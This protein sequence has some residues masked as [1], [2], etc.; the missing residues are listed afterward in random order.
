MLRILEVDPIDAGITQEYVPS[1]EA[2]GAWS[3]VTSVSACTEL[4]YHSEIHRHSEADLH[5][6]IE[7]HAPFLPD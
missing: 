4:E 5:R 3:T 1:L 6:L 7:T 2:C